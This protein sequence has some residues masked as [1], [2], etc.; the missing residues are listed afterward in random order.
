MTAFR[1]NHPHITPYYRQGQGCGADDQCKV[2]LRDEVNFGWELDKENSHESNTTAS[3]DT[4]I[5]SHD[6]DIICGMAK[7]F[8]SVGVHRLVKEEI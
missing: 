4:V 7:E 5:N 1:R 8:P 6:N 2:S 3:I